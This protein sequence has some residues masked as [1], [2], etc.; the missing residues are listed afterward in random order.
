M[1]SKHHALHHLVRHHLVLGGAR[2]GKSRHAEAIVLSTGHEPVYVATG[3]AGDAEMAARIEAH[4]ARR[5]A[6]WRLVEEPLNLPQALSREAGP[7]RTVLVDCLTLWLT[8]LMLAERDFE[9]ESEAL[10]AALAAADGPVVMVSNEVGQGLVPMNAMAR[11]F[12]D[13]AGALHQRLAAQCDVVE[14]VVAGLP[15]RLKPRR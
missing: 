2:S 14:L 10:A 6:R 13:A 7:S 11:A 12:V 4:Q 15:L 8:N 3:Q 5:G 1:T 9:T